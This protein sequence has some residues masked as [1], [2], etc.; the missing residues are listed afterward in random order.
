MRK[1]LK[2]LNK[3]ILSIFSYKYDNEYDF[4]SSQAKRKRIVTLG[5]MFYLLKITFATIKLTLFF[6]LVSFWQI[7]QILIATILKIGIILNK[8][9]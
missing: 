7:S 1:L 9:I 5:L 4:I 8:G 2:F 6:K 3:H